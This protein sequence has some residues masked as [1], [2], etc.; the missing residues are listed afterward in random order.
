MSKFKKVPG[1]TNNALQ[2]LAFW[3]AYRET[4]Y[5]HHP[6]T[7]G[8]IVHELS[9]LLHSLIKV[10]DSDKNYLYREIRYANICKASQETSR[11]R[12]DILIATEA[13]GVN[14]A[15]SH[16]FSRSAKCV[17]EVK[18]WPSLTNDIKSD[19]KRLAKVASHSKVRTFLIIACQSGIPKKLLDWETG[20]TGLTKLVQQKILFHDDPTIRYKVRRSCVASA[21]VNKNRSAK[22]VTM[23]EVVAP[24]K[25]AQSKSR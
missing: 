3:M 5:R 17:V 25:R 23:I 10:G 15:R 12:A 21:S 8:A 20:K 11:N 18:R 4:R 7:E 1:W 2:S 14:K 16:D 6:L 13:L 24:K 22:V 9:E 19:I